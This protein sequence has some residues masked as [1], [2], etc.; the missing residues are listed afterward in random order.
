MIKYI[1]EDYTENVYYGDIFST[2]AKII[3]KFKQEANPLQ[4]KSWIV[5]D[6]RMINKKETLY[7][8][9]FDTNEEAYKVTIKNQ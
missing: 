3:T 4:A 8:V 7:T 1:N 5:S 2:A 9:Y 6:F